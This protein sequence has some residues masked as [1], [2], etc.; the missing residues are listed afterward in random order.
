MLDLLAAGVPGNSNINVLKIVLTAAVAGVL[1]ALNLVSLKHRSTNVLSVI[2]P[3]LLIMAVVTLVATSVL[4]YPNAREELKSIPRLSVMGVTALSMLLA[5]IGLIQIKLRHFRRGRKR[6]LTTIVVG[7]L[8]F[9][10]FGYAVYQMKHPEPEE[11]IPPE[12]TSDLFQATPTKTSPDSF[13]PATTPI[14]N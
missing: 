10:Q 2:A 3:I 9:G 4:T 7:L 5:A 6:A 8:L 14:A 11:V 1:I 12:P 13:R